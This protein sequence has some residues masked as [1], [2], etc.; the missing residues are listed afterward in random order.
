MLKNI[1]ISSDEVITIIRSI[2]DSTNQQSK[3]V[4]D[5]VADVEKMKRGTYQA[6]DRCNEAFD[7]AVQLCS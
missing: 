4:T 6:V 2:S 1:I 3:A 7:A 5:M